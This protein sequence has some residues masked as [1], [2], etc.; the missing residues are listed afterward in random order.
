MLLRAARVLLPAALL[1]SAACAG[2][3]VVDD[4]PKRPEAEGRAAVSGLIEDYEGQ[5]AEPFFRRFDQDRFP[6][7]ETFRYNTR[8]FLL[9][10]HQINMQVIVDRVLTS[11]SEVSVDAHWNRSL[12]DPSGSSKL[13]QG[14]CSFIFT[15][16]ASGELL[17]AA[18]Q[19]QSPF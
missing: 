2:L 6:N 19:G 9:A 12:V 3:K 15:R 1:L 11:G 18:I 4:G 13:D 10:V 8:E 14:G 17:L 5:R 16:D 7:W